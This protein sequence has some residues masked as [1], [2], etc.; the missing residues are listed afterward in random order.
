MAVT[1][2]QT[3]A[4]VGDRI[5]IESTDGDVL[6]LF[7]SR[8]GDNFFYSSSSTKIANDPMDADDEVRG[9][10]G[11]LFV[12]DRQGRVRGAAMAERERVPVLSWPG[13]KK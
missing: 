10:L 7:R 6:L 13:R 11:I 3:D 8:H 1:S 4:G 9:S 5:E 2:W 12:D